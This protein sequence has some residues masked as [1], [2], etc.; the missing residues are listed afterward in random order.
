[1]VLSFTPL[2]LSETVFS[3]SLSALAKYINVYEYIYNVSMLKR[4]SQL[5]YS[6]DIIE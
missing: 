4:K 3:M 6:M 1:M 5:R 2:P